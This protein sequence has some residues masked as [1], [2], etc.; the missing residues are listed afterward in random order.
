MR[1]T[2]GDCK[3]LDKVYFSSQLRCRPAQVTIY[4]IKLVFSPYLGFKPAD[5][6]YI[7]CQLSVTCQLTIFAEPYEDDLSGLSC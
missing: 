7:P 3:P 6:E 5:N 4:L 1:T 2:A